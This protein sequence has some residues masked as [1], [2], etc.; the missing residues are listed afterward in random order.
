MST[1][2]YDMLFQQ[3]NC[4]KRQQIWLPIVDHVILSVILIRASIN[5]FNLDFEK[6]LPLIIVTSSSVMR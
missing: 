4:D 3:I 1:T 5:M 2:F 6:T